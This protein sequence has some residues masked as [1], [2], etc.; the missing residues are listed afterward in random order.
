MH[1]ALEELITCGDTSFNAQDM[2][3]RVARLSDVIPGKE[4][5]GFEEQF[6]VCMAIVTAYSYVLNLLSKC[7]N[8]YLK[9]ALLIKR[10][11]LND[12]YTSVCTTNLS[13]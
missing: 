1:D 12:V 2:I 6:N 7:H 13:V 3:S 9:T 11:F 10:L 5:T 4:V 8:H